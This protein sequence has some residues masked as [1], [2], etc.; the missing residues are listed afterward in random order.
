[1]KNHIKRESKRILISSD[2]I[3]EHLKIPIK[4]KNVFS[5]LG[6]SNNSEK[7]TLTFLDNENYTKEII[8]NTNILGV[9]IL[10][11]LKEIIKEH[12]SDIIF[13]VVS[14]PRYA[15]FTLQNVIAELQFELTKFDSK[16][17][18]SAIIH[19]TSYISPFNVDIGMNV[20]IQPNVTILPDVII[21]DD[22]IIR[23]G[24]VIGSEGFEHKRTSKGN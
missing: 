21:G 23:P 18:S 1:M 2:F 4:E 15:F 3:Q 12:R 6:L 8:N 20:L 9:F 5:T 14:D 13:F 16:I 10:K 7:G 22:T 19:S 24:V 11:E 17:D